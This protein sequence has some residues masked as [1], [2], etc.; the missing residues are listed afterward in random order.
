M[1]VHVTTGEDDPENPAE[2]SLRWALAQPQP[3]VV[4]IDET[5]VPIVLKAPIRV[6]KGTTIG[7][8]A[9][10]AIVKHSDYR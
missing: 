1:S 4:S 7:G 9:P 2:G 8:A 10:L 3:L 6:P 5:A